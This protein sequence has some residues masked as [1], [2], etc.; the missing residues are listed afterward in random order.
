MVTFSVKEFSS[1]SQIN[2]FL[3]QCSEL[4]LDTNLPYLTAN[5]LLKRGNFFAGRI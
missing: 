4:K 1:I 3:L 5:N 2:N